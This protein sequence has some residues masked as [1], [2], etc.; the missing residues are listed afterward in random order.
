MSSFEEIKPRELKPALL[1]LDGIS[2][3]SVEALRSTRVWAS[4]RD[5]RQA[6]AVDLAANQ[7]TPIAGAEVDLRSQS[8][9]SRIECPRLG[10][11]GGDRPVPWPTV[12]CD[13]GS[14]AARADLKATENRPWQRTAYDWDERRLFHIGDAAEHVPVQR[15]A[16]QAL[17]VYAAAYSLQITTGLYIEAFFGN[18]TGVPSTAGST[19]TASPSRS[20][21][22]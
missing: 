4:E 3:A 18:S 15:D 19:R 17:D 11:E 8:A 2:R 13:F 22:P 14:A 5:S 16:A 9:G 21:E 1:E 20:L 12:A 7:V 6:A 10:G